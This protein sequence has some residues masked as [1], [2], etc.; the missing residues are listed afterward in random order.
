LLPKCTL[1]ISPTKHAKHTPPRAQPVSLVSHGNGFGA[2]AQARTMK[3]TNGVH[4]GGADPRRDGL[5]YAF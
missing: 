4:D 2:N 1:I 3:R 5:A